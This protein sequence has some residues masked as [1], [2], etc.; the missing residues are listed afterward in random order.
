MARAASFAVM[1]ISTLAGLNAAWG[2]DPIKI[3]FGMSLTGG[4][5]VGGKPALVTLELWREDVN[6]K[7]GLLRRPVEF[8]YYDD[9]TNPSNVPPIYTKLLDVDKVDLV[10]SGYGTN[11][12]AP[13]MPIVTQRN[14]L[15]M[16]LFGLAVN[17]QF[18]YS[19]F[20]QMQPN[21]PDARI[22][23]SLG[24]LETA[25]TMNPKPNKLAIVGADAEFPHVALDGARENAKKL[26]LQIVYDRTYPP[27]SVDFGPIV[28]SIQATDPD[29]VYVASYPPDSVGITRAASEIGLKARM[30]GGAMIGLQFGPI[31]AQLGPLLKG[32]VAYELYVPEPTMNF[33]GIR[34]FLKRYQER[35]AKEGIDPL[36]FYIAPFGYAEMQI[37]QQAVTA[38][39]SLDQAKLADY[40]HQT[41]FHTIVGDIKFGPNG[42]WAESRFLF[43][44]YRNIGGNGLEQFRE[45]GRQ[46]ILYPPQ[47]KSGDLAFPYTDVKH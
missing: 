14:L 3:G 35:A 41:T 31:K 17:D 15:F 11:L 16:C 40:I 24:F 34:E 12:Q 33:P 27:N 6:A 18:K 21:G 32:M 20:F 43:V 23:A 5:A 22:A 25:L 19:R 8:V 9:Q 30:F 28:R 26:G 38:V 29:V 46:V 7:G 10:V 39:G 13:A 47:F 37:L 44:Q 36:G 42:E 45:P 1:L 2:A 4:L